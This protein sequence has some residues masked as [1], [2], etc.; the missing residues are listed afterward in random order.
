MNWFFQ[1]IRVA[2]LTEPLPHC[3]VIS[4]YLREGSTDA[5]VSEI[6]GILVLKL[7]PS[8]SEYNNEMEVKGYHFEKRVNGGRNWI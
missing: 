8:K 1:S 7:S 6:H 2:I 4:R 3:W 5:D